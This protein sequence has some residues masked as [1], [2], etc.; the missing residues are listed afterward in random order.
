M[1]G[2][3]IAVRKTAVSNVEQPILSTTIAVSPIAL[4][5]QKAKLKKGEANDS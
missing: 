1:T 2:A 5:A 4:S 3:A